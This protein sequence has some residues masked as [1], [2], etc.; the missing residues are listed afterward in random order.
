MFGR[1]HVGHDASSAFGKRGLFRK[2]DPLETSEI[3][4]SPHRVRKEGESRHFLEILET[5]TLECSYITRTL[6]YFQN[7]F[8]FRLHLHF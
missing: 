7:S 2:V 5:F 8:G 4:E 6:N 3:L 1:M